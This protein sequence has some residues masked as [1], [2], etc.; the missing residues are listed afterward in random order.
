MARLAIWF[1]RF[2]QFR[3]RQ[4]GDRAMVVYR[5]AC[6]ERVSTEEQALHGASVEAQA[7]ALNAY[8]AQHNLKVVDHYTDAG[9]SGGKPAF[10]RQAMSRLLEDVKAGKI[11]MV[12]FTKLDRWF[13]NVPEYFKVQEILEKHK[14][15]WKTVHED[16]DTTTPNGRMTITIFLAL[17]QN[18]R[19][20]GSYRVKAV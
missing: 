12:I 20:K 3:L 14:V 11:D 18:E 4:K 1:F 2:R 17:A 19:E 16:F 10:K 15:E 9:V 6:Y 5:V 7:E 8:C 13:R